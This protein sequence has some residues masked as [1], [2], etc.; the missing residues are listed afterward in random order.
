MFNDGGWGRT[1]GISRRPTSLVSAS[2]F[3]VCTTG[4]EW[5]G[6]DYVTNRRLAG[7]KAKSVSADG[8]I[9]VA[10]IGW[11]VPQQTQRRSTKASATPCSLGRVFNSLGFLAEVF[12]AAVPCR[13]D[14]DGK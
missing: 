13:A 9:E 1:T 3:A 6:N 8:K 5:W 14:L 10:P 4:G 11:S 2:S 7:S 12:R